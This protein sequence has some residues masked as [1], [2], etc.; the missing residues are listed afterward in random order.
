M[1]QVTLCLLIRGDKVLLGMKKRGF[2]AGKWNGFGG[3][4]DEKKGD[5]NI[6]D[7]LFRE[8]KEETGVDIENPQRVGVMRFRFPYKPDWDQ[9]VHLF[10]AKEWGGEPA[11][12]E[13][14]FPK[15]FSFNEI[16]YDK[17]WDDDKHWLPHVLNGKKIEADFI[18]REGEKTDKHDIKIVK[19]I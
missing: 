17:M 19:E 1:R 16:P 13:E 9:D 5:K 11:E 7:A 6:T 8:V 4:I 10:L 2:G 12:S 14:M 18:F 3:K 15:W